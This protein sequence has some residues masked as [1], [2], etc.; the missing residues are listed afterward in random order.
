MEYQ[1][2]LYLQLRDMIKQ[3]IDDGEYLPGE[4]LPSEREMA[5]TFKINRMTIKK[6]IDTLVKDG[7]LYKV[8]NKGTFV[9]KQ[10][11]KKILYLNDHSRG[12]SIGLGAYFNSTGAPLKNLVLEK[13]VMNSCFYVCD[14]LGLSTEDSIF[15][16]VRLRVL[17]G[18]SV[19]L[20]YCFV[21]LK[22]FH[23]INNHNFEKASLYD[24]MQTQN[25][26]PVT[27]EQKMTVQK[28]TSPITRIMKIED[29]D[30]VY[31]LEYVG[32]D[33][34]GNTVE[35]TRSYMRCDQAVYGYE[36]SR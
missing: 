10:P 1:I 8:N 12:K 34:D 32:H 21:P 20:E 13:G 24:Y 30:F 7:I 29:A 17:D 19:A 4:K 3:K 22:F 5:A 33:K 26:F 31:V 11:V 28:A 18:E 16:L 23:D 35:F 15:S 25:H 36:I 9:W 2:P 14:K 6:A 27:F